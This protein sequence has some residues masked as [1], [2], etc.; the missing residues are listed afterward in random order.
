[1]A[2]EVLISIAIGLALAAF[3]L[4]LGAGPV[5]AFF[6]YSLGGALWLSSALVVA[7]RQG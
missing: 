4:T 1:M 6:T 5:S 7:L 2:G 3:A